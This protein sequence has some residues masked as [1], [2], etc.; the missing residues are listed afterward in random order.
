MKKILTTAV[1][2]MVILGQVHTADNTPTF[3]SDQ[4]NI[5]RNGLLHKC[6]TVGSH[7]FESCRFDYGATGNPCQGLCFRSLVLSEGVVCKRCFAG[8]NTCDVLP[9]AHQIIVDAV[10]FVG[11]C[12]QVP[13]AAQHC[14]CNYQG[15]NERTPVRIRCTCN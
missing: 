11:Q 3:D 7:D 12:V 14:Q 15:V 8:M 1:A 4:S 10:A 13:Q 9:A 2:I 6:L 5:S